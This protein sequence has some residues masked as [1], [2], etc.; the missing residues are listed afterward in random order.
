MCPNSAVAP[1][2]TAEEIERLREALAESERRFDCVIGLTR[3]C[4]WEVDD[5]HRFTVWRTG[6]DPAAAYERMLGKAP[7]ELPI[8]PLDE[9]G[10]D[11]HRR[12][13]CAR[14]PFT[15]FVVRRTDESGKDRFVSVSG[16]PVF[17]SQGRF[18]GYRGLAR[19]VTHEQ[20]DRRLLS[21]SRSIS[22]ILSDAG[23]ADEALTAAMRAICLSENWDCGVYWR[24]DERDGVLRMHAAWCIPDPAVSAVVEEGKRISFEPGSGLV[25]TV[26]QTAKPLWVT[27]LANEPRVLRKHVVRRTGWQ[28]AFLFP[29]LTQGKAIGVLDFSARFIAEPDERL[30]Q[31]VNGLGMQIGHYYAQAQTMRQLRESEELYSSTV[32][33]AAIGISHIS[34]DGRFIHVNRQLCEML[35]YTREELLR[36]TVHQVSHPDDRHV[37]DAARARLYAGEIDSLKAEKRYLRKDG[38]PVWVRITATLK[39]DVDGE[40]L[41]DISVVEDISERK[42]AEQRIQYLASHDEMT[43][44]PNRAMFTQLLDEAIEAARQNGTQLAVLFVDLDRFKLINDSLGHEAGDRLLREIASRFQACLRRGD[45][46]ARLGGDE[47]VVL[48]ENLNRPEKAAQIA[49]KLLSAAI[50]PV[51][52]MGQECRVTASIGI[53]VF[54]GDAQDARSLIKKADLAM[55][56]A[57]EEGKNNYQFYTKGTSTLSIE[58]LTLETN[59][60][61][62]L[63]RNEFTLQYQP[64]VDISTG[65]ITGVEALLRWWN[66]DLGTVPPARF[67][68]VAE[69]TGLIV[70]IGRW[71]LRTA[72]R[73]NVAW[74]RMGLKPIRIGVNLSP[75]Q[76]KDQHL[77]RDIADALEESG[78]APELLE[79]ELTESV[80]MHDVD[81]AVEKLLAIKEMGVR[82]AIDDFGTGYS[83]LAQLKRFPID[84]LKVDRSFIREIPHDVEDEAITEAII[85]MGRT[86]GVTVV[87]EGVETPAQQRFLLRRGCHEMQGYLFGKPA[88]PDAIAEQL[89]AEQATESTGLMLSGL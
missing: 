63:E 81:G 21:L 24:L 17:D 22:S 14:E 5:H 88:H 32:E 61:R 36:L 89:R 41:Y 7:W 73:Q 4:Y 71:V 3:D 26:W 11:A 25:G 40:P 27:D 52:I 65:K 83:S 70:P 66:R 74:Q 85:A 57:K 13:L 64:K 1:G 19:D 78:M 16:R 30:L 45:L 35:G 9:H 15:D 37:T 18:L 50:Q 46:V 8:F 2:E 75:R 72:C 49:R 23:D 68:P 42:R 31:V 84:T 77:L 51:E 38:S 43:G 59:L 76:F 28:N 80:V 53:A 34:V 67:I 87:A 39:R 55:Y 33:L 58:R 86:L 10:W 12:L 56:S 44:L 20:R 54:P 82:L 6:T 48:V 47:F 69:D 62:A 79:L 60:R 29:V